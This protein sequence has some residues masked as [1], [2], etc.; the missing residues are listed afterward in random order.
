MPLVPSLA[1]RE[2]D[3]LAALVDEDALE[4]H[5]IV[6]A[7]SER[8]GGVSRGPYASLDLAAHVGDDPH[9]VD[10]N[11]SRLLSALGLT[12]ARGRLTMSQQ[13]HGETIAE[14]GASEAGAGAFASSGPPP[15]PASDALLTLQTGVPLMMCFADC[16]PVV[17]AVTEP[18][19]AVA[20]VHAGW[21]GALA[22]LPG[23]AAA[24][25]AERA[26]VEASSV[27]AWVGPRICG[28]CFEVGPEVLSQFRERFATIRVAG[29]RVDLG[30]VVSGDLT[31]AGVPPEHVADA[32]VCTLECTG[33]FYSYRASRVTGRHGAVAGIV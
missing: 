31:A 11:R 24:A 10:E 18:V 8:T 9:D 1:R 23:K 2:R 22:G 17:L 3:G 32:G 26:G 13:V 19:R 20:V 25:L 29:D 16:V 6:V 15:L 30:A 5:G 33:R 28:S 4:R 7:F 27:L 12:A 14:V 21:R